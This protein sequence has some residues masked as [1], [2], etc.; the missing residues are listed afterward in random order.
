MPNITVLQGECR[1]SSDPEAVLTTVLGSCVAVCL[2]DRAARVG[3]MNHFLLPG[4]GR[5]TG[6]DMRFG[7]HSMELLINDVLKRGGDRGR[8]E[9]KLFGGASVMA[10]RSEI[11]AGNQ[12]FALN[13]L[14]RESIPI[15]ARDLGG[16]LARRL[17][18]FPTTG[19]VKHMLVPASAAPAEAPAPVRKP[20]PPAED[21]TLF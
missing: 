7:V 12:K 5:S 4:D 9:S 6:S 15:V 1:V 17:R 16:T 3:G 13:F 11:G 2:Y 10:N 20:A 14:Q 21:V 8:L 18:F 19:Q